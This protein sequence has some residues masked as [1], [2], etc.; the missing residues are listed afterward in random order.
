[1][2][3]LVKAKQ[4]LYPNDAHFY[5]L[6]AKAYFIEQKDLLRFQAQGEAY[7]RQYNIDKAVEQM[8]FASKEKDGTFYEKSIV[9]ARLKD[10]QRLQKLKKPD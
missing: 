4:S 2:I 9:E 3:A 8:T 6:L 10:L 5:E 7:Y 1:M